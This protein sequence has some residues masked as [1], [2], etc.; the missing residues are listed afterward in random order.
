MPGNMLHALGT[1]SDFSNIIVHS[2]F[3]A[4]FVY[5]LSSKEEPLP[6]GFKL[7]SKIFGRETLFAIAS[8]NIS[9]VL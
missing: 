7:N 2:Y 9:V 1:V 8:L 3:S 5:T 6:F 4:V